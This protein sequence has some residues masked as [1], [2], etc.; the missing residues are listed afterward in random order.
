MQMN[1]I[2]VKTSNVVYEFFCW[3][4]GSQAVLIQQSGSDTVSGNVYSAAHSNE[5]VLFGRGATAVGHVTLVPI[6]RKIRPD[7]LH[8][9][10]GTA[11]IVDRVYLDDP[12]RRFPM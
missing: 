4:H 7:A 12:H 10:P 11:T 3:A 2:H 9:S 1:D 8:D 5:V 6:G